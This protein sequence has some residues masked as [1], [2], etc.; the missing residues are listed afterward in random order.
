MNVG[1]FQQGLDCSRLQLRVGVQE[2]QELGFN[3]PRSNIAGT[4][5]T[6]ILAVFD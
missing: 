4:P 3:A 1:T 5:E 2:K 6:K